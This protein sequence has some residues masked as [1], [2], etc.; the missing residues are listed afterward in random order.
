MTELSEELRRQGL[1][2][3][4]REQYIKI[5]DRSGGDPLEWLKSRVDGR[6]PLGT[7]LPYRAAVKKYMVHVQ[8][9]SEDEAQKV[10]PKAKGRTTRQRFALDPKALKTFY[11]AVLDVPE[12]YQT[13]LLLLPRT[14]LRISEAC[15]LQK[16]NYVERSG[17]RG[18]LFSGKGAVQ[19]FVPLSQTAQES[20][21][22]YLAAF[23]P[24]K[25][26]FLNRVGAP[27][28][29]AAVRKHTRDLAKKHPSLEGLSPHVLR[30]TFATHAIRVGVDVRTLQALLGHSNIDT[31]ARY[32]HPDVTMLADAVRALD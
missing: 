16:K 20:L 21:D 3:S 4:T 6:T 9:I 14:G 15:Y 18:L 11:S 13:L 17:V 1:M 22:L 12:P 19:R 27:L 10:L 25:W 29:P 5:L 24:K 31:T 7:V 26:L 30:H 2:P 8:G 32:L 28:T 23:K